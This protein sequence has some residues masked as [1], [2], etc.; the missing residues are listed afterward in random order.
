[1]GRAAVNA[2]LQLQTHT[3]ALLSG[4]RKFIQDTVYRYDYLFFSVTIRITYAVK[5]KV[6]NAYVILKKYTVSGILS[7]KIY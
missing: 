2:A 3:L 1:M 6:I 5:N 7:C 4:S